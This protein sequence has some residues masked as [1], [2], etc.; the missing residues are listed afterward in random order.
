LAL[1]KGQP[2]KVPEKTGNQLKKPA[3]T[4]LRDAR[5]HASRG[6]ISGSGGV[7]GVIG[8]KNR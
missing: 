1:R 2:P 8:S 6:E 7:S 4:S 3:K 5:E